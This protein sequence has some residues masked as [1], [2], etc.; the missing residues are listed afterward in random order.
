MAL[1]GEKRYRVFIEI[2][3]GKRSLDISVRRWEDN[4]KIGIKE[5][6][7]VGEDDLSS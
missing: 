3:E 6:G 7:W 1:L 2:S 5:I 4:I